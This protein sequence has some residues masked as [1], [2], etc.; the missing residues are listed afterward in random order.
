MLIHNLRVER[1]WRILPARF[2]E[3]ANEFCSRGRVRSAPCRNS[4]LSLLKKRSIGLRSGEYGADMLSN[5]PG[6]VLV[7]GLAVGEAGE[8]LHT[9]ADL[10]P[11]YAAR[12]RRE[13]EDDIFI[14]ESGPVSTWRSSISTHLQSD[15][16]TGAYGR[17]AQERR[18]ELVDVCQYRYK[19]DTYGKTQVY[20]RK[21]ELDVLRKAAPRAGCG[22]A[23]LVRDAIRKVVLKPQTAGP[24]SIWAGEP[25]RTS[26]EHDSVHDEP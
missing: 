6:R 2:C 19:S 22:I 24:V 16:Q 15:L 1:N 12:N 10:L 26:I 4:A 25:R 3:G 5:W 13:A 14:E 8:L 11:R 9:L 18:A 23:E 7:L 21:E 17:P 20:L